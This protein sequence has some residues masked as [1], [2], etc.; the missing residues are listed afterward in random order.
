M[1]ASNEDNHIQQNST[2]QDAG[3]G[4]PILLNVANHMGGGIAQRLDLDNELKRKHLSPGP[5]IYSGSI[6]SGH[7]QGGSLSERLPGFPE[8]GSSYDEEEDS[9]PLERRNFA[10]KYGDVSHLYNSKNFR[11]NPL[12]SNKGRSKGFFEMTVPDRAAT[13]DLIIPN[14]NNSNLRAN[15]GNTQVP[16]VQTMY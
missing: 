11:D 8:E 3:G 5:Q 14:N 13:F 6:R 4:G 12:L 9:S 16:K 10:A 7:R 15:N 2:L 1:N